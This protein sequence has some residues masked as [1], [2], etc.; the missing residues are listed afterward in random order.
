M[1]DAKVHKFL[2]WGI[3]AAV[4]LTTFLFGVT[5]QDIREI[6]DNREI[7]TER[8]I[9]I[10]EDVGYIKGVIQAWNETYGNP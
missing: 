8:I 2:I 9:D 1:N 3:I 5:N 10:K 6:R 4:S 7:D